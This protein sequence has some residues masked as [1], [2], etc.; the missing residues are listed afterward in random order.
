MG[1]VGTPRDGEE[2]VSVLNL[3]EDSI[4]THKNQ[5][6]SRSRRWSSR[7]L[8]NVSQQNRWDGVLWG[9]GQGSVSRAEM[10]AM[11]GVFRM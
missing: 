1:A 5:W 11:T 3:M 4:R 2:V 10:G 9:T 8:W 6:G 7:V